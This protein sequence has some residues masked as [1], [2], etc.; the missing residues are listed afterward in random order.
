MPTS[1]GDRDGGEGGNDHPPRWPVRPSRE[2]DELL[3]S[4]LSRVAVGN[5]IS[6]WSFFRTVADQ[7]KKA[8]ISESCRWSWIDVHCRSQHAEYIAAGMDF[9][10]ISVFAATLFPAFEVAFLQGPDLL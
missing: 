10:P 6:P 7:T 1:F 5:G 9:A 3:S 4:W 2:T 8:G